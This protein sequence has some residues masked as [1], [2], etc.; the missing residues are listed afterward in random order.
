MSKAVGQTKTVGKHSAGKLVEKK[1]YGVQATKP[2]VFTAL[3]AKRNRQAGKM[4]VPRSGD[5]IRMLW[6]PKFGQLLT[7]H[8][9]VG[10]VGYHCI[11]I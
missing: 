8:S 1:T 6:S 9:L 5:Q 4:N 11:M 2:L 3:V 7:V 10:T